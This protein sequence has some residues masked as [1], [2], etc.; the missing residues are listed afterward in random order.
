MM[1]C[2]DHPTM[3]K[4]G[5]GWGALAGVSAAYLAADGYTGAP[6][7]I[8]ES[9][10]VAETWAD[11]GH[12]WCVLE[13]YFKP[14]PVCRWAQP[15]VEAALALQNRLGVGAEA[16]RQVEVTT[17]HEAARLAARAPRDTEAAQYSL[18]FPVACA[19][20]KGA[21]G[22][23]EIGGASLE[24]PAV[25][26]LASSMVLRE[27]EA[28]NARFPAERWG[29][30]TFHLADG[31]SV[32][33]DPAVARGNQENPLSDD[34]IVT[35]YRALSRPVMGAA[36]SAAIEAGVG[37]LAHERTDLGPFLDDLLRAPDAEGARATA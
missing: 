37:D 10:E 11:L 5:S 3:V 15:A 34:E 7:L 6:A 12:R 16:I 2:I 33:S 25:L 32:H 19:L 30:V 18:P 4:D 26:A 8:V 29:H 13:Q 28:Y 35:K 1:R 36:R 17:F 27:S 24:D 31:T 22:A 9:P 20:V 21:L 14:Y 23:E